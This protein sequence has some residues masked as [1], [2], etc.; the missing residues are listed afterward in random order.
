MSVHP[1]YTILCCSFKIHFL[2]M[3]V[4]ERMY[5]CIFICM[6]ESL[7]CLPETITTLLISCTPIQNKKFKNTNIKHTSLIMSK[8]STFHVFK[9]TFVL[10]SNPPYILLYG[11]SAHYFLC[12]WASLVAEMVKNLSTI[13][14]TWVWSLGQED[15]LRRELLST[16]LFLPGEFHGQ[17]SL[18]GYIPWGGK[19]S[20]T[21]ERL[22]THTHIIP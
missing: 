16:P 11:L 15:P 8:L 14:D 10:V 18:A 9:V 13:Q 7:F 6:A 17:R 5:T 2:R 22:S 4:W 12:V 21:T 1:Y 19:E 3:G 20:D